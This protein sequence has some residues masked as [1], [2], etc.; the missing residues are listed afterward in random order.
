MSITIEV[1][2]NMQVAAIWSRLA[3]NLENHCVCLAASLEVSKGDVNIRSFIT[4]AVWDDDLDWSDLSRL[5]NRKVEV[6]NATRGESRDYLPRGCVLVA[7]A[8]QRGEGPLAAWARPDPI[9]AHL[10]LTRLEGYRL[11]FLFSKVAD[12]QS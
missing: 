5:I 3:V 9:G 11:E 8:A 10:S 2:S 7:D 12:V 6:I 1:R 4:P